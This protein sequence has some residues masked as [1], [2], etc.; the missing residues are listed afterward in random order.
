MEWTNQTSQ[1]IAVSP[2]FPVIV[3]QLTIVIALCMSLAGIFANMYVICI[4]RQNKDMRTPSYI[5]IAN[6]AV[7]NLLLVIFYP[8]VTVVML[9]HSSYNTYHSSSFIKYFLCGF[10]F[11]VTITAMIAANATLTFIAYE[12]YYVLTGETHSHRYLSRKK[13]AFVLLSIWIIAILHSFPPAFILMRKSTI[14][15]LCTMYAVSE[16]GR[17]IILALSTLDVVIPFSLSLI[18]H[19]IIVVILRRHQYIPWIIPIKS[20]RIRPILPNRRPNQ[21]IQ[22]VIRMLQLITLLQFIFYSL[23]LL[24]S[25]CTSIGYAQ[26]WNGYLVG[27]SNSL[28]FFAIVISCLSSPIIYIIYLKKFRYPLVLY[29][30]NAS[31]LCHKNTNCE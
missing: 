18:F 22:N 16:H 11:P 14:A 8:L 26:K 23:W 27:F 13:S 17:N 12:R 1:H 7:A 24:G 25:Y 20:N 29:W 4:I 3:L 15:N 21:R 6:L 2:V 28:R 19:T 9:F 10:I 5:A 30:I 31:Q